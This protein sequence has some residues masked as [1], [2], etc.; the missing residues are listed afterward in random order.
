MSYRITADRAAA[1][2]PT[3]HWLPVN[4]DTP[5]GETLQLVSKPAGVP[6]YGRYTAGSDWTHWQRLPTYSPD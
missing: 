5:K 6:V 4:A 1:V 2:S 3:V